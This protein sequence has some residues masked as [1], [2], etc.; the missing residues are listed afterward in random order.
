MIGLHIDETLRIELLWIDYRAVHVGKKFELIS[1][2]DIIAIAGSAIRNDLTTID[3]FD[4][5]GLEGLNHFVLLRHATDP[6]IGFDCHKNKSEVS[7]SGVWS[8][9]IG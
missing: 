1:A 3:L 5:T 7:K 4:L 6:S 8:P 9:R 2:S